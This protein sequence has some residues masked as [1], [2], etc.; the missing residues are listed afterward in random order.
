MP[1]SDRLPDSFARRVAAQLGD[2]YPAFLAALDQPP[3]VGIRRNSR[4]PA[5]VFPDA[6][7]LPWC[8][9]GGILAERPIFALDPLWHAG[10]YYV[11]EP[12]S[13]LLDFALRKF[14]D[15][16]PIDTVLDLCAAPGGKTT[17]LADFMDEANLIV[18]NEPI[19]KRYS[20]LRENAARWGSPN[21][22]CT[23]H[24]PADFGPLA[25]YFNLVLV[26]APCSGEGLFRKDAAAIN[27]WSEGNAQLCVA[28]QCRILA[29]AAPLVASSGLLIYSTC[30]YN[31][32]ENDAQIAELLTSEDWDCL[33]L[34][35]PQ[36]W[37]LAPT[38]HGVQCWPHRI[39]G[40]GFYLA[41][42]HRKM[43][44][45]KTALTP[46][47]LPADYRNATAQ[48]IALASP[49][50]RDPDACAILTRI[51]DGEIFASP[52]VIE[53]LS[54]LTNA[55]PRMSLGV[56]LGSVKGKDFVPAHELALSDAVNPHLPAVELSRDDA[57]RSL[58]RESP[59]LP[60]DTPNGWLLMRHKGLALGWAKAIP[61]RVNNYLPMDWRLRLTP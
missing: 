14:C 36:E 29:A 32:E 40:E 38:A 33:T 23:N 46:P 10:A 7:P 6:A 4:K 26:D 47:A 52:P 55:L 42:L 31:P 20:I 48:E 1:I 53:F 59:A 19:R 51:S 18:A 60:E 34:D 37:G 45:A 27:E 21:I 28:R 12:S 2:E 3:P 50:L 57:L 8:P 17:L 58:R 5:D 16:W 11:Q 56:R 15:L 13:M 44:D 9:A 43:Y 54:V 22:V 49:F 41:V 39:P 35:A 24:A 25:G 30:T 61:G